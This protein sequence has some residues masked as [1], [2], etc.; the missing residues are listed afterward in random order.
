MT[1]FVSDRDNVDLALQ[2]TWSRLKDFQRATVER[3]AEQFKDPQHSRRV[4]VADE[5]GLGKTVVAKG[6]IVSMLRDWHRRE[7]LRVTYICSNLSLAAENLAKLAVFPAGSG[8]IRQPSY[9]RLAQVAVCQPEQHSA[10]LEICTL[11]PA[12]SFSL[13]QGTGNRQERGIILAALLQHPQLR[14]FRH[15]L[16]ALFQDRVQCADSWQAERDQIEQQ[17]L[18]KEIVASFHAAITFVSNDATPSLLERLRSTACLRA[19]RHR[20][21]KREL[22]RDLRVTFARCCATH[23]R[24][25]LFILDEFQRFESLLDLQENEQSLIAREIFSRERES[26]VLMLSATP[27]K[28]MSTVDDDENDDG[29]LEKLKQ[30]LAFL[31]LSPLDAYE[32]ARK[33]LQAALLCLR[34]DCIDGEA[35]DDAPRREVERLLRP[36]ICRTERSQIARDVDS[37]V[38]GIPPQDLP[39]L[40]TDD[41]RTYIELDRL[42]LVLEA[43][44][45]LRVSSQIMSFFKSAAW[46]LSFSTGYKVQEV[47]QRRFERSPALFKQLTA[48]KNLWLSR[49]RIRKFTLDVAREAPNPQV[50]WLASHLFGDGRKAGPEMLL[51]LPPSWPHYRLRGF[52]AGHEQLSKTLLFSSWTMVPRMVGGLMSYEAE[53]R[54]QQHLTDKSEYFNKRRAGVSEDDQNRHLQQR[55]AVIKL[56]SGDVANWSLIYPAR[57]LTDIPIARTSVPLESR[58]DEL[59]RHFTRSLASLRV[60]NQGA[61]NSH[62]WYLFA[63]M[64]LD[65]AHEGW[66]AT[67]FEAMS[68]V[69]NLSDGARLRV[70]EISRRFNQLDE[71]GAMPEDL[72]QYLARLAL[73][74][75]AV[76]A[77][78]VLRQLYPGPCLIGAASR[79]ALGFVSLFNSVTGS[80]IARRLDPLH[81][82][83]GIVRYCADGGIQAMLEEYCYLLAPDKLLDDV[84]TTLESVL[85]TT[86]SN[87]KVWKV[88]REKDDTHLRCHYAVQLGAQK[89]TD[90]AGQTRIINIRESFN[91]PF[92]PFVLAST[93][94]GQEGLDFHWYCSEVVHWNL[95]NNPIDLEQR[96]G[97]VNRYQS[98]VVRRR[99][100]QAV[101]EYDSAPENWKALFTSVESPTWGTDLVPY[102]HYPEGDAKIRRLIPRLAFSEEARRYPN[103][104]KVLSLYRLAFGQ[105][106]QSEMLEHLK[107]LN[108]DDEALEHIKSQLLIRLAPVLYRRERSRT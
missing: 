47:L 69:G 54:V 31:N 16:T 85:R 13:T 79:V 56:D 35:L 75:P 64:L 73:G 92:R 65:Q 14:G 27:F 66:T 15:S 17:G 44:S 33:K 32:P 103:M 55:R 76:C 86:P 52:F 29:H 57:C 43:D 96:E 19:E 81:P 51:W 22:M 63:P 36:L 97:R 12:T 94:I 108:L 42:A 71:L 104:Q 34:R 61:Q 101:A 59:I 48:N 100:V 102:W 77:Y 78:R 106:G 18:V 3:I 89:T 4:L 24:A 88:D 38:D 95:P 30:I 90:E 21:V 82:W 105:P 11:T 60:R 20:G 93:S 53:R 107:N 2:M 10:L 84:V 46:P 1:R 68:D 91:S 74:S 39:Q 58:L 72:P 8:W 6:L 37:L 9:A 50:R 70:R 40:R 67:W 99:V 83:R 5:V 26:N 28:A 80:A 62:Y 7:P 45:S 41:I 49:E 87:V 23:L 25:D 98:L